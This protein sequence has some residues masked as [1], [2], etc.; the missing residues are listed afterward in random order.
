MRIYSSTT[1]I[2]ITNLTLSDIKKH[3]S[4]FD[5]FLL[6]KK[7]NNENNINSIRLIVKLLF[8]NADKFEQFIMFKAIYSNNEYDWLSVRATYPHIVFNDFYRKSKESL[9]NLN[10]SE[11]LSENDLITKFVQYDKLKEVD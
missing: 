4:F 9:N 1:T 7:I 2:K 3:I 5:R 6:R 8:P 10:I 11:I